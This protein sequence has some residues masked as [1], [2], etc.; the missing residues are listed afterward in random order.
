MKIKVLSENTSISNE[1]ASEHGL[2]LFIQTSKHNILFD[3]GQGNL[4][5]ENA[6]KLDVDLSTVDVAFI[7]HGHYDHG[8]GLGRF[9]EQ[10]KKA[11]I[12][13]HP[14]IFGDYYAKGLSNEMNYIGLDKSLKRNSRIVFVDNFIKIDDELELFSKVKQREFNPFFNKFLYMKNGERDTF[15]HEQNLVINSENKS[16]LIAGCAHSGI[17]N[18]MNK[19]YEIKGSYPDFVIGGFHLY[20]NSSGESEKEERIIRLAHRLNEYDTV[21]YTGH[22]TG[23]YAFTVM[24]KIMKHKMINLSTGQIINL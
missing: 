12:Y 2:S 11:K 21:F 15:K 20:S 6:K 16:L 13:A 3:M 22:C 5:A 17:V 4:F 23:K 7:S 8:G 1:Y 10:N 19:Y 9:L 18:I 24:K 14:K